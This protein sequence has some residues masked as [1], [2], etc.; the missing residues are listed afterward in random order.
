[1]RKPSPM[2]CPV[3]GLRDGFIICELIVIAGP[4]D[5]A[6]ESSYVTQSCASTVWDGV[7][8]VSGLPKLRPPFDPPYKGSCGCYISNDQWICAESNCNTSFHKKRNVLGI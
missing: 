7:A 1:M 5:N 8:Q 6:A 3:T 2:L 4:L